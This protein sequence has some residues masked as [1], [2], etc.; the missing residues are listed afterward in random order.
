MYMFPQTQYPIERIR[1]K[2]YFI[3][4]KIFFDLK[5][6]TEGSLNYSRIFNRTNHTFTTKL[7]PLYIHYGI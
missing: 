1:M 6:E 3:N 4:R 5:K 2:P 7:Y